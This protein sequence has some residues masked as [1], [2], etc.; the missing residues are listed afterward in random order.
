MRAGLG[1]LGKRGIGILTRP[2]RRALST[3]LACI[4]DRPLTTHRAELPRVPS[5]S[6]LQSRRC[7]PIVAVCTRPIEPDDRVVAL[8][9]SR[10]HKQL[11]DQD[12]DR[13]RKE[14]QSR[15][16]ERAST[17]LRPS[18]ARRRSFPAPLAS[19]LR[20]PCALRSGSPVCS[21]YASQR[22]RIAPCTCSFVDYRR[23]SRTR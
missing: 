7:I 1:H 4:V 22:L 13:R 16:S 23:W 18:L 3:L 19:P 10:S 6:I 8:T 21:S 9:V 5:R 17:G 2:N 20:L 11:S 12:C 15:M 14:E